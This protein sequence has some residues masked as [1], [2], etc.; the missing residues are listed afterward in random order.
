MRE[1]EW[2]LVDFDPLTETAT[3]AGYSGDKYYVRT[4]RNV[5]GQIKVN[6]EC[7]SAAGNNWK[8]DM[9]LVASIPAHLFYETDLRDATAEHDEKYMRRWLNDSDNRAWRTKEGQI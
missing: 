8:G 2:H 5:D 3:Y 6:T 1:N 4:E 9:H 7:R